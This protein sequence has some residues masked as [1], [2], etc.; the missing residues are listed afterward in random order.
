MLDPLKG[1]LLMCKYVC[2]C[3]YCAKAMRKTDR[4]LALNRLSYWTLSVSS[5][6]VA[7]S[8]CLWDAL[9]L[10]PPQSPPGPED[11]Y[12][13]P[14][15]LVFS[16]QYYQLYAKSIPGLELG[17]GF[18]YN[19]ERAQGNLYVTRP[20]HPPLLAQAKNSQWSCSGRNPTL[21]LGTL[22]QEEGE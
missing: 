7:C 6:S 12:F 4:Y 2:M 18:A 8:G 5:S 20:A 14:L 11:L 3:V 19:P 17:K 10:V 16:S 9:L 1:K 15:L 22:S 21:S 13:S